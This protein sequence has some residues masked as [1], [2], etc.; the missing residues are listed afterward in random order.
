M[1]SSTSASGMAFC[2]WPSCGERS[3]SSL[4]EERTLGEIISASA[5]AVTR[6]V[7][8]RHAGAP[9]QTIEEQ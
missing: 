4:S 3:R 8:L 6:L 1:S 9:T 7:A 2:D 5:R